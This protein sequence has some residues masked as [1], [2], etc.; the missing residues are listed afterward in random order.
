[1]RIM[2]KTISTLLISTLLVFTSSAFADSESNNKITSLGK[3]THPDVQ[4]KYCVIKDTQEM[5]KNHMNY[6]LHRRAETVREGMR[7][8][9]N[10]HFKNFSLERCINCHARDAQGKPVK[11]K[12]AN[13]K[14]NSEHFCQSCHN[15]TAV[16]IDC[17]SCHSATPTGKVEAVSQ[18][19]NQN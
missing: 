2:I 5:R 1:M 7:W 15:Y 12:L 4:G 11:L 16:S 19:N 8:S 6:I 14:L 18:I 3:L 13:G 10:K 17:F 9:K